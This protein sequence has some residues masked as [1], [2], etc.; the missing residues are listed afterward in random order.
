L[1]VDAEAPELFALA[2]YYATQHG[3]LW[4]ADDGVG[5]VATRPVAGTTWEICRIYVHPDR[6]GAG[7]GPALLHT[8]EAHAIAAGARTLTLWTDTRFARAHRFYEKQHYRRDQ[9][10]RALGDKGGTIEYHYAK[11]VPDSA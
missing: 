7:L 2:S 3:A 8:A 6:H 4:V 9:T 1:D 5:M 11:A 10:T